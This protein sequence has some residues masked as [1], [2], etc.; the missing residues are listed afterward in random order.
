MGEAPCGDQ[1]VRD[2]ACE[3]SEART[4]GGGGDWEAVT[5]SGPDRGARGPDVLGQQRESGSVSFVFSATASLS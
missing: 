2:C 4:Q 1:A 5:E 3:Q